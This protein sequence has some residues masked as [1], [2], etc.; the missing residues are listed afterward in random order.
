[1]AKKKIER[2]PSDCVHDTFRMRN[3]GVVDV[4][5]NSKRSTDNYYVDR[6]Q[7]GTHAVYNPETGK[8]TECQNHIKQ[9]ARMQMGELKFRSSNKSADKQ[10]QGFCDLAVRH[11]RPKMGMSIPSA[12]SPRKR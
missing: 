6:A 9:N 1:M 10:R 3:A 5:M 4:P 12:P 11:D 7:L 2:D 8:A